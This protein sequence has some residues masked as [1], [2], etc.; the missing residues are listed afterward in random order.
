[1]VPAMRCL[2]CLVLVL[3]AC[4]GGSASTADAGL[5]SP[6]AADSPDGG[7]ADA[8]GDPDATVFV[9]SCGDFTADPGWTLSDGFHAVVIADADDGLDEPVAVL[10]ASGAFGG[11]ILAVNQGNATLT[12]TDP[13]TGDTTVLVA[14]DGWPITPILL[15]AVAHDEDGLL[16]GQIYV[17][18]QGS[19]GDTDSRVFRV[20]AA[21]TTA[22]LA[23]TGPG[24]DDVFGMAIL[25][26]TDGWAGGLYLTGDTDGIGPDWGVYDVD[27]VGT[28]FSEV[29]GCE[30]IA[31]DR[32]HAYGGGILASCPAG[33]GYA[34]S[35]ALVEVGPDGLAGA[36]IA[37][38][39]PGIH[40]VTIAPPGPFAG[41]A[42]VASWSTGAL[43]SIT[44]AG[45]VTTLA[46]GLSLTNYDA[47]I[48]GFSPDGRVLYVADRLANRLVCIEPLP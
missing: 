5:G 42:H 30:G 11:R 1:M 23:Q 25:P 4:G 46:S 28:P 44:P 32:G 6:D 35:D 22:T 14:A 8:G 16:D 24:L 13:A 33:G 17:A 7:T 12:S 3:A 41:P 9:Y 37:G 20:D 31:F 40:A 2:A 34:G 36:P 29:A 18:D 10:V 39:L 21:G 48:L 43:S 45:V 38:G 27:G 26:A 15:T 47:N 19:D